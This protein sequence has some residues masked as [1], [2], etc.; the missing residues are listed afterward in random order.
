MTDEQIKEIMALVAKLE[1]QMHRMGELWER[2]QGKGWPEPESDEFARLRDV[3][4][5]ATR[6]AIESALRAAVPEVPAEI[7]LFHEV[8]RCLQDM[9]MPH[10]LCKPRSK[11]ACTNCNAIDRL[12]A[13][14]F[15][16]RG[17]RVI[18]ASPQQAPQAAQP[19]QPFINCTCFNET[20]RKYCPS[21]NK[22][23]R[24]VAAAAPP[25]SAQQAGAALKPEPVASEREAFVIYL[26]ECDDCA[27]VPD[28]AGSFAWA[29]RAAPV[30]QSEQVR[31]PLSDAGLTFPQI[32][33]AAKVL[34]DRMDYPWS[35]MPQQGRDKMREIAQAVIEAAHHIREN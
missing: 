34:A 17:P 29:W 2:R 3:L 28:V 15:S 13:I 26:A 23:S 22:C 33:A 9:K 24:I 10:G 21:K 18:A 1:R 11:M 30:K 14:F 32:D 31:K 25:Q 12:Q 7:E 19:V 4:A 8:M 27:I 16:Y 20:S 6:K 5:P 35:P